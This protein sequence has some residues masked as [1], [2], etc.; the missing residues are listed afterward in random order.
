MIKTQIEQILTEAFQPAY[1]N[2]ID[3]SAKHIGHAGARQGGH[4]TV[5]I[6]SHVFNGKKPVERHRMVY[7]ALEPLKASIHALSIKSHPLN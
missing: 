1:L 7:A 5:E 6:T 3:D 2:V 4:F